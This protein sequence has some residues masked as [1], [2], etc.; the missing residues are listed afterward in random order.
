MKLLKTSLLIAITGLSFSLQA[1]NNQIKDSTNIS[2]SS[3]YRQRAIE[4]AK[5]EQQFEAKNKAEED[6]FW[7]DQENYEKKLK[8]NDRK[9]YRAYMKGKRDAY[10]EHYE[11]CDHEHHSHD[12]YTHASFYYYRYEDPYY[13]H[14]PHR[15]TYSTN[16][17]VSTP[18]IRLGLF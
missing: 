4:D 2:K 10:A 9:A 11:H 7:E 1:Q 8:R 12:Y 3:Y 14:H 6:A 16:V 18:S 15:T 5:F 17:R 13:Y